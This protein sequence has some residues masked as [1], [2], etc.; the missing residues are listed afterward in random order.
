MLLSKAPPPKAPTIQLAILNEG[1]RERIRAIIEGDLRWLDFLET[2]DP[3]KGTLLK[4]STTISPHL[5]EV[6]AESI[7]KTSLDSVG[8]DVIFTKYEKIRSLGA[9][10]AKGF[11][12]ITFEVYNVRMWRQ[13]EPFWPNVQYHGFRYMERYYALQ[14]EMMTKEF[15]TLENAIELAVN[16]RDVLEFMDNPIYEE[17]LELAELLFSG[18]RRMALA[19]SGL[20]KRD[21]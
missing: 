17:T 19:F 9:E 20:W 4:P 15:G 3:R 18:E 10:L 5:F 8:H 16:L 13:V 7:V 11:E 14:R 2:E 6:S 21:G 12:D 1:N